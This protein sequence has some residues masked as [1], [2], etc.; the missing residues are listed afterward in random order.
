MSALMTIDSVRRNDRSKDWSVIL[1][2]IDA[3]VYLPIYVGESQAHV[4]KRELISYRPDYHDL[5]LEDI[6]EMGI[7]TRFAKLESVTI[8]SFEDN[9]FRSKLQLLCRG[10]F[11]EID[12]PLAKAIAL[13]IR[14]KVPI[15]AEKQVLTKAAIAVGERAESLDS[16]AQ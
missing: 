16:P 8:D 14:T 11:Y 12:Y 2:R 9:N 15:I 6:D 3:E 13:S 5:R 4:I 7:D 1:K 10:T